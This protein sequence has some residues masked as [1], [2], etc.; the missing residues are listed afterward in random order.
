[1]GSAKHRIVPRFH[2]FVSF[3]P[4]R[5]FLKSQ[6]CSGELCVFCLT[7]AL[8]GNPPPH[9]GTQHFTEHLLGVMRG[10]AAIYFL[11]TLIVTS[12]SLCRLRVFFPPFTTMWYVSQFNLAILDVCYGLNV[13]DNPHHHLSE[14]HMLKA[15]CPMHQEVG[16]LNSHEGR[17]FMHGISVLIKETPQRPLIPS[18]T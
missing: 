4:R 10:F 11:Q 16:S 12:Y 14:F 3:C 15:Q 8:D 18:T 1:M 5:P 7:S 17:I 13:C 2:R 6:T 9:T